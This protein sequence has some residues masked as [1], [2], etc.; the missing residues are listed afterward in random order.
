MSDRD[1]RADL[2]A[3]RRRWEQWAGIVR[4]VAL[5]RRGSGGIDPRQYER[6]HG[7]LLAA[8]RRLREA[9]EGP[10]QGR[11]QRLEV[12]VHPWL[13]PRTLETADQ[14]ILLDLLARC[15]QLT[16][17]LGGRRRSRLK[18][19]LLLLLVAL[20]GAGLVLLVGTGEPLWPRLVEYLDDTVRLVRSGIRQLGRVPAW[21]VSCTLI[22][23]TAIVLLWRAVRA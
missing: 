13:T 5:G 4:L 17:E 18:G 20:A 16:R 11:Y 1:V 19:L 6:L 21:L 12:L 9:A 7:E 23:V 22:V 2:F 15:E 14:Q 10:Q 3:L 8:C